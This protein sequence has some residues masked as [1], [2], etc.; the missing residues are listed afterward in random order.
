MPLDLFTFAYY[1][2]GLSLIDVI[3]TPIGIEYLD[4][5]ELSGYSAKIMERYGYKGWFLIRIV[6]TFPLIFIVFLIAQFLGEALIYFIFTYSI[7]AVFGVIALI[8]LL[9]VGIELW[10]RF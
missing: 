1:L 4:Q 9:V 8:D 7:L 3:L 2:I 5:E 6:I 10:E